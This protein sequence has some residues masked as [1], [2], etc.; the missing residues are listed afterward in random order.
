MVR[1]AGIENAAILGILT[2]TGLKDI[3]IDCNSPWTFARWWAS[4]RRIRRR[5]HSE[6]DLAT[7]RAAGFSGPEG[8]PTIAIDAP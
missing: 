3:C 4:R 6:Q 7:L 1:R 2:V 5:P 8:D